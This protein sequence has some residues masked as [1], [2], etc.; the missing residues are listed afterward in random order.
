MP[1]MKPKKI[2]RPALPK[3]HAKGR[4]VPVRFNTEDLKRITA[5]AKANHQ[6]VSG[7]SGSEPPSTRRCKCDNAKYGFQIRTLPRARHA[8]TTFSHQYFVLFV[9]LTF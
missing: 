4:I 6:T 2:G 8:T 9:F 1:Q 5:A 3:G 7:K